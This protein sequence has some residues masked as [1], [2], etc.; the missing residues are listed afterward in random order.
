[1][2]YLIAGA[3]LIALLASAPLVAAPAAHHVRHK[4]KSVTVSTAKVEKRSAPDFGAMFALIDKMFPAQPDPDPARIGL[5]RTAV[6]TM[7]P[8]GAY[9]KMMSVLFGGMISRAMQ[10]KQSDFASLNPKAA[11]AADDKDE[12][13]HETL[14][15]KDPY[16]DQRM[17][18]INTA[19]EEEA[20]KVSAIIDPR[21]REGLSRAMA[22]RF[23]AQQ[24]GDINAFFATPTGHAFAGQYLRLWL[25]PDA[26]RSMFGA[27]PEMMK[28]MPEVMQKIKAADDK[29]PKLPKT[30]PAVTKP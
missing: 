24:L 22:R 15:A 2:R 3:S 20:S 17:A 26:M 23:D 13:L 25:D 5:A 8:D 21:M 29:F 28:M 27:M 7:W 18:A 10:L 9:G 30:T 4:E 6:G 14:A 16:F 11:K 19:I 12:S 1:M